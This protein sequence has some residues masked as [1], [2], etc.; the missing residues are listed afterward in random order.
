VHLPP[1]YGVQ[2]QRFYPVLYL[3]DGQ[4]LFDPARAAFGRTWQVAET[5]DRL[6]REQRIRPLIIVGIDNTPQRL[7]EYGWWPE[8]EHQAGG[9]GC[10][11]AHFL[12]NEL[13]PYIDRTYRTQPGRAHTGVAGASMGGL[14]SL[15]IA[16]Q[17]P[18][19]VGLCGVLSP[20]LWWANC[21]ILDELEH[22]PAW[23]KR[24]RF[25][26]CMGSR[27]GRRLR[28][29]LTPH[30]QHCRR[31]VELWDRVGLLPGRHY[32]YTEV[33]GGEH[34]EDAWAARFDKVL[35]YLFGWGRG[36]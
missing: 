17:Y 8:E 11:Y 36:R 33:A 35:L 18:E 25:W 29:H 22:H 10:S 7:D 3:H 34:N 24:V 26:M 32:Y 19:H 15:A 1:G 23:M 4:N 9:K 6:V 30:L 31:L 14:I 20:S 16:W 13:K 5:A 12:I 2:P 28:G 27:E 21:R